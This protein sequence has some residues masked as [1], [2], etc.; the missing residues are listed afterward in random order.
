MGVSSDIFSGWRSESMAEL[1]K[2]LL[3]IFLGGALIQIARLIFADADLALLSKG[4]HPPRAFR[5]K[6][7]WITGASQGFGEV[8]AGYFARRGAKII[9][10]SR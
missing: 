9:L 8:L 6:V 1:G 4:R 5:G 2:G 7:V 10:S 3:T